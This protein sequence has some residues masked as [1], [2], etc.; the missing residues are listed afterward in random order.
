MTPPMAKRRP[1]RSG[2]TCRRL[3]GRASPGTRALDLSAPPPFVRAAGLPTPSGP[4]RPLLVLGDDIT[5][6]H[7]SP[8]NQIRS[9]SPAGRYI[10]AAG[11]DI[12]DLNVFAS[13]RGNFEVMLRGAFTNR[14][15]VN[16]LLPT[17]PAG[18]TR[19]MPSGE[20]VSLTRRPQRY[21][22]DGVPLVIVAGERYGM[23]S[24]R[25]W[26]AKAV[27]LLGV[28]A[29]IAA[30]IERIHRTNLIGMGILPA[31]PAGRSR[32]SGSCDLGRGP[33][34]SGL[35]LR[36]TRAALRGHG[37]D[38]ARGG[39]DRDPVT[40]GGDRYLSRGR[41]AQGW[42]YHSSCLEEPARPAR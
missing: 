21:G 37:L 5:T 23:G 34:R 6:D 40:D 3:T 18:L 26:A 32:A 35:G 41:A 10:V 29:I 4:A 14:L 13:R 42:R 17:S 27:A 9:D 25:D 11:G 39:R 2:S 38:P 31:A 20:I 30:S 22:Q 1:G 28:R 36:Q 12:R 8:A 24:S 19:H 33:V 15:A 7:I 16:Q